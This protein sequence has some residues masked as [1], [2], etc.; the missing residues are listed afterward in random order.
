MAKLY[1]GCDVSKGYADF[2]ILDEN[3]QIV[4]PYF[5]LDDTFEG[6]NKLFD[7]LSNLLAKHTDSIMYAAVESTGGLE[8][9][10]LHLF[11]RLGDILN[12]KAAR[13]NPLGPV[14][15]HKASLERNKND[16]ISAQ[17]VAEYLIAY[18]NKVSYNT[19]DPYVSLR[20]QWN[21]IQMYSKQKTQLLNLLSI[22]LYTSLPFVV[23]YCKQGVPNWLLQL[24]G[25]YPS[26]SR[27]ARAKEQ[28]I[29]KIPYI[30]LKRAQTLITDAKE[31][32]GSC[33]DES[34]ALV[35]KSSVDQI[36]ALKVSI[37]KHKAYMANHCDLPEVRL[38]TTFP[39]IGIYSAIGLVLNII[40]IERFP[41]A[42]H[43]ASYFGVH[44]VYKDSGDKTGSY[45]MSKQ[46]RA[47]PRSILFMIARSSIIYNPLIKEV[48][49]EYLKSGKSKMSVLGI[50]M[51][52]ILRIIFGILKNQTA[53]N[54]EIDRKNRE[55]PKWTKTD[56]KE[57]DLKR[58][59]LKESDEAPISRRQSLKRKK[60]KQSQS[61]NQAVCGIIASPSSL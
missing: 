19:Q 4:E 48:Y 26:A 6:H 44:P 36:I 43:L 40:S 17:Y 1:L 8:D 42:K 37:E 22:Y 20:K 60:R 27:I 56:K 38:L 12:I 46:G 9:N 3:K 33:D 10:W 39:G 58:R 13:I 16:G 61:H 28:A 47:V 41:S 32:I 51:H 52:K 45:R 24:L 29:S 2:I 30:S 55:K 49:I 18:P 11:Y 23:R 50:C 34:T 54:P 35:I 21:L 57:S 7:I 14:A 59:F 25:K 5:Q 53:F 15:L 31:S